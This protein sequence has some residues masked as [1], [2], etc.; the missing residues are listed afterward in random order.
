VEKPAGKAPF[1][2]PRDRWE[3]NIKVDIG[4]DRQVAGCCSHGTE[5]CG[6]V[7]LGLFLNWLRKYKLLEDWLVC[8]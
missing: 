1:N 6:S 5:T 2:R 3:D 7:K 4:S 8:S